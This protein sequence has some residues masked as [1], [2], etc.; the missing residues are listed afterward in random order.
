MPS[1]LTL[2]LSRE[3]LA[4]NTLAVSFAKPAEFSFHAGQYADIALLS[5]PFHDV[6]GNLRTFSIVSAPFQDNLEFVMRLS[7]TAFKRALSVAH[8]PAHQGHAYRPGDD[9]AMVF[10]PR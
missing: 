10:C 1:Y 4:N 8:G 2:L 5:S 6:W 3:S 9:A 7:N